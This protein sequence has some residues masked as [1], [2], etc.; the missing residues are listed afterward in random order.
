MLLNLSFIACSLLL[1]PH[2]SQPIYA[3]V[4]AVILG[5]IAQLA[6]Q[7]P[8]LKKIGMIPSFTGFGTRAR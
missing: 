4:I 7:L 2:M 8:A 1:A 3:L 5:G 6:F